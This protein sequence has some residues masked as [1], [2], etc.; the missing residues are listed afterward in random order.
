MEESIQETMNKMFPDLM[1]RRARRLNGSEET[2]D[3]Q[4][5]KYNCPICH[6]SGWE[7]VTG[8]DG[9]EFCRRCKCGIFERQAIERK[10]SFATIP[11]EFEGHTVENFK[12]D[13]YSTKENRELAQMAKV[14]AS[15]YVEQFDEIRE[16][17]KGLYFYSQT[18]GSG[19]TRLAVSIANDLIQ[20]KIIAA[21]F[22]TTI[23][24]LDQIKA[25]WGG[26][27]KNEETEQKLIQ[28]IVSVPVL[29]I[30]DI[31]VEAVKPWIKATDLA[32][33]EQ[34]EPRPDPARRPGSM[35]ERE[36]VSPTT[37]ATS[38]NGCPALEF[39][40]AKSRSSSATWPRNRFRTLPRP[41]IGRPFF[42]M[43]AW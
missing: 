40:K 26:E 19:K 27:W 32:E 3:D 18:K 4:T 39:T 41:H 14:I 24:I 29:V 13:C 28:E 9:Y 12:T 35:T 38:G 36:T 37:W 8:P 5:P 22:A 11:K 6:D 33:Q 10:L 16:T 43:V 23:Q 21:K 31:G 15:R 30:D 7:M 2:P 42:R 34:P 20:K 17:G 25:T 1:A